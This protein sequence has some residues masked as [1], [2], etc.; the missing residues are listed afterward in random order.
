MPKPSIFYWNCGSGILKKLDHIKWT[1]TH[2]S[3]EILFVAEADIY[4][5]KE[6]GV[7][8]VKGYNFHCPGTIVTRG[9]CRLV[10]WAKMNIVRL[11]AMEDH[12]NEVIALKIQNIT[13]LGIYRPFKCYAG[14]NIKTNFDRLINNLHRVVSMEK[15]III[16][17][18]MNID[19]TR[20]FGS[21][22]M[23]R[24][25]EWQDEFLIDQIVDFNTRSRMVS[26]HLQKSMIDL[27]YTS[28]HNL[29]VNH[30][31]MTD[32]DHVML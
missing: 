30:D 9:K 21:Y 20:D 18:D 2:L 27:I 1:L 15:N 29:V 17:G 10:A 25:M 16:M 12:H 6:L 7:F 3:P 8:Q 28:V 24:I 11:N 26:G 32:S 31:F 4:N 23:N 19:P 22:F 14:E 5:N 13:C